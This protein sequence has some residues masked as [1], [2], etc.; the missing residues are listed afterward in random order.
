MN[1][2]IHIPFHRPSIGPEEMQAVQDVLASGWLTT[3]PVALAFEQ[4]FAR[5]IGCKRAI[6]VNSATAA[7]QLALDAIGL[8][9]GDE[10]LH[11]GPDQAEHDELEEPARQSRGAGAEDARELSVAHLGGHAGIEHPDRERQQDEQQ[12]AADAVQDRHPA[13]RREPVVRQLRDVDVPIDR[14][15]LHGVCHARPSD[16]LGACRIVNG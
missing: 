8:K 5:Y 10:V 9:A 11:V 16:L 14:S 6:A 7:L 15:L 1:D 4:E 3:G 12:R 13:R 2:P